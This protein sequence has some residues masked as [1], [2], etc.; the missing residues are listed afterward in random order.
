VIG[1]PDDS[2]VILRLSTHMPQ[3]ELLD[4]QHLRAG[5]PGEPVGRGAAES[6]KAQHDVLIL[7]F[8]W[9][10]I[11]RSTQIHADR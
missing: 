10:I 6:A 8:R 7:M 3:L 2:G 1:K 11:R 5:T 9:H 4:A